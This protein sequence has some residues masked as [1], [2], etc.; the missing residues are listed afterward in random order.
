M[1]LPKELSKI[2]SKYR[3]KYLK[4]AHSQKIEI[5]A[6]SGEKFH[7]IFLYKEKGKE[8]L[9]RIWRPNQIL[10]AELYFKNDKRQGSSKEFYLSGA[11]KVSKT[12]KDNKLDGTFE[13]F[14]ETGEKK[15][16]MS[17]KN[18]EADGNIEL[19]YKDGKPSDI[20][21]M[22]NGKKDGT[23]RYWSDTG[24]LMG[25]SEWKDGVRIS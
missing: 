9:H 17:Y 19:W 25:E 11:L 18:G 14:Y 13:F 15:Y 4:I 6:Y 1:A 12:F 2:V 16:T 24:Q 23:H 22:K 10:I 21:N 8:G 20:Y 5:K 7:G 3:G